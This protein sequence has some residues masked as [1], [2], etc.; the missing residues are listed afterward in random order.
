MTKEERLAEI[1]SLRV[2]AG[3]ADADLIKCW[4]RGHHD[5]ALLD[6]A[7]S[8]GNQLKE[9]EK[10]YIRFFGPIPHGGIHADAHS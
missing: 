4:H 6:R 9:A 2:E 8:L 5:L 7:W 3:K 1:L 10:W